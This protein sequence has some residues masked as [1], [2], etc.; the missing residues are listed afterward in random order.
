MEFLQNIDPTLQPYIPVACALLCL[1]L[2]IIGIVT[3]ALSGIFEL[4]STVVEFL[5]GGPAV[6][7]GCLF[8]I[9]SLVACAGTAFLLL[10]APTSCAAHPTNFCRWFGFLP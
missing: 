6:W 4:V 7:C 1:A 3:Q 10:N 2:I 8:L 5:Q 9:A